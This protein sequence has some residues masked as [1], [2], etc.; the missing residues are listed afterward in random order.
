MLQSV[1]GSLDQVLGSV[2]SQ[3]VFPGLPAIG[4]GQYDRYC[5]LSPD[6][7]QYPFAFIHLAMRRNW[8][9]RKAPDLAELAVSATM[10]EWEYLE[11]VNEWHLAAPEFL[12]D[13]IGAVAMWCSWL[14][15]WTT[16]LL[17][18]GHDRL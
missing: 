8:L 15:C 3:V 14:P 16:V 18:W 1:E 2:Q 11:M 5:S 13:A 12:T 17:T 6:K 9:Y 7:R 4:L 10:S